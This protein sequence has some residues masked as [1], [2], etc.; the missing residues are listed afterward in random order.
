MKELKNLSNNSFHNIFSAGNDFST[1][2][3]LLH[4]IYGEANDA[5]VLFNA[6]GNL[7]IECNTKAYELF[8]IKEKDLLSRIEIFKF[9]KESLKTRNGKDIFYSISDTGFWNGEV[10]LRTK[11][12]GSFWGDAAIR[13]FKVGGNEYYLT[14]IVDIT[15]KKMAQEELIESEKDYRELFEFAHDAIIVFEPENEIVLDVNNQACRLYGFSKTDFTGLSLKTITKDIEKGETLV[16]S[17]LLKGKLQ[18]INTTHFKKDGTE[19]FLE[20]NAAKINYRGKPA[21]IIVCHDVTDRIHSQKQLLKTQLRLAH[22]LNNLPHIVLYETGSG[23]EFISGNV[24]NLLGYPI[25]KFQS[26]KNF[27]RSLIHPDDLDNVN[28]NIIAWRNIGETGVLKNEYR[29]LKDDG[30]Y[31]WLED[32]MVQ[33]KDDAGFKYVTGVLVDIT[34]RKNN[35]A[36]LLNAKL[37]AESATKAKSDFLATMSHEIRT[38]MNGVIGMTG[39]LLNTDLS[40]EQKE[41]VE[42]IRVSGEALLTIINDILDYS[43]IELDKMELE[44]HPFEIRPCIEESLELLSSKAGEKGIDLL[45]YV[46]PDVPAS[47]TGDAS[48]LRQVLVNLIG[49]A[50]KFTNKGEIFVSAKLISGDDNDYN[51]R[52]SVKDTGIGIPKYK[53]ARLFKPFSQVDSSTTRKFGGTGLGLA[54]SSRLVKLMGGKLEVESKESQGSDFFFC[55]SVKKTHASVPQRRISADVN[56]LRNKRVLVVDDNKTNLQILSLQCS[57]WG[58]EPVTTESPGEALEIL[59]SGEKFDIALIDMQMPGMDGI[60]LGSQIRK[61]GLNKMPAMILLTSIGQVNRYSAEY[62]ELFDS[63]V[64][65]PVK[66][67]RLFDIMVNVLSGTNRIHSGEEFL[68]INTGLS[69]KYPLNIILAEDNIIN[70]KLFLR[71]LSKMGYIADIANNGLEA[72]D[73][74]ERQKY[75]IVFM[76]IQMPEM[77]GLEASKR[78]ISLC[79]GKDRPYIVAV[80]ANAMAGDREKYINAGMDDYISKPIVLSELE[81][82]LVKYGELNNNKLQ[83]KKHSFM[84]IDNE[85]IYSLRAISE[86]EDDEFLK[87]II[88]LYIQQLKLLMNDIKLS[89]KDEETFIRLVHTLKGASLN[90]GAKALGEH[91]KLMETLARE[92]DF[93]GAAELVGDLNSIADRTYKEYKSFL[94]KLNNN[95]HG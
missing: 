3:E 82:I 11:E 29:C 28:R 77:D 22:I 74:I 78:I 27:F 40:K 90:V 48:R 23:N 86:N 95:N 62:K 64:S 73:A 44:E 67:S 88:N 26:G 6:R 42:T 24:S 38:P 89:I 14:R 20:I 5:I 31:I 60:T 34:D 91:A 46:E 66:Q 51:I 61:L 80:T 43:K 1:I 25:E 75:D 63:Y 92:G 8:E 53:I 71:M 83:K 56:G 9:L 54:I 68:K 52:I 65:K 30:A 93:L 16:R 69:G 2:A 7:S 70:Q 81:K 94:E 57:S 10:K 79:K 58:M 49:N 36:E 50:V 39:L 12:G 45:Y 55:I 76:D 18:K 84:L 41:F 47:V 87:E 33:V 13:I 21:I 19:L 17:I 59:G 15:S 32:N 85:T 37:L 35:E 72:L 4:A